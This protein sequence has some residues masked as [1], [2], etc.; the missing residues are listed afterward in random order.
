MRREVL[1]LDF[2]FKT[3]AELTRSK[4]VKREMFLEFLATT[5][6]NDFLLTADHFDIFSSMSDF[7]FLKPK[8]SEFITSRAS[9]IVPINQE[10]RPYAGY[11]YFFGTFFGIP[12]KTEFMLRAYSSSSKTKELTILFLTEFLEDAKKTSEVFPA[13]GQ[14]LEL[15]FSENLG[16]YETE[17]RLS[18]VTWISEFQN[19]LTI[20]FI[21]ILIPKILQSIGEIAKTNSAKSINFLGSN[22]RDLLRQ[23]VQLGKNISPGNVVSELGRLLEIPGD[24]EPFEYLVSAEILKLGGGEIPKLIEDGVVFGILCRVPEVEDLIRKFSSVEITKLL[25]FFFLRLLGYWEISSTKFRVASSLISCLL[26]RKEIHMWKFFSECP[27]MVNSAE[28]SKVLHTAGITFGIS[29]NHVTLFSDSEKI[30][31]DLQMDCVQNFYEN[32][33]PASSFEVLFE[34]WKQE[35]KP[36][37]GNSRGSL[38]SSRGNFLFLGIK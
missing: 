33:S 14:V 6:N 19:Y 37:L 18:A 17:V 8:I 32:F 22:F 25:D 28:F 31:G 27:E 9:E 20:P 13:L 23:S 35:G 4:S 24:C 15:I 7:P 10:A 3:L 16:K 21:E 11:F 5:I 29:G 12:K 26:R 1:L 36:S 30:Y 34:G 2:I 38:T